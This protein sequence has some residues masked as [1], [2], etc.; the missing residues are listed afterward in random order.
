[1]P[2]TC[3]PHERARGVERERGGGQGGGQ[4][5]RVL[6]FRAAIFCRENDGYYSPAAA[7]TLTPCLV[8]AWLGWVEVRAVLVLRASDLNKVR[9]RPSSSDHQFIVRFIVSERLHHLEGCCVKI[10]FFKKIVDTTSLLC[11]LHVN[12]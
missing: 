8:V 2:D 5:A 12:R 10:F 3:R 6:L 9:F 7:L 4:S 11:M 1:M